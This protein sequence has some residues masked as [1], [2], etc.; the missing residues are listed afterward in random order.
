L[1]AFGMAS[2]FC[3]SRA[4]HLS[5]TGQYGLTP[6]PSSRWPLRLSAVGFFI[7][8]QAAGRRAENVGACHAD[9]ARVY[10]ICGV[11]AVLNGRRAGRVRIAAR[12]CL[13]SVFLA[14]SFLGVRGAICDGRGTGCTRAT[15]EAMASSA[16][17]EPDMLTRCLVYRGQA[18]VSLTGLRANGG[19]HCAVGGVAGWGW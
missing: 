10:R 6:R 16:E 3:S 9:R 7:A 18:P 1:R 4:R 13:S 8:T 15:R 2:F 19:E 12:G 5:H 17:R 11:F 14:Y